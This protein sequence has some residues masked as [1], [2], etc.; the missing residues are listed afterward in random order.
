MTGVK[1]LFTSEE[2]LELKKVGIEFSDTHDYSDDEMA[3]LYDQ[4]ADQFPYEYDGDGNP[5]RL[6]TL[7]EHIID[8]LCNN[9]K[10]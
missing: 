6:G 9:F 2:L 3:D 1:S 10:I 8:T 7:F 4:V 5:K